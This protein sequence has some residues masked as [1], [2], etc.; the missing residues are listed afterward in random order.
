MRHRSP[1][2]AVHAPARRFDGN[3]GEPWAVEVKAEEKLGAAAMAE[4]SGRA[5]III[6]N[7]RVVDGT[8]ASA[9]RADVAVKDK[10]IVAL[11]ELGHA[12]A[13]SVLDATGL[14]VAPGFIDMHTHSDLSLLI[15][16]R[17]E[18]KLRQGVTTEVIGQCGF[19]PAPA[20][21]PRADAVRAIFGVWGKEVDWS[22]GSYGEYLDALREAGTSV[23]V[24]PVVGHGVLRTGVMGE[25]N[26]PPSAAE[27]DEM[28]AAV[29][30]AMEEGALG[31]SSG[32]AYA[33][34]MFAD[35]EELTALAAEVGVLGGI[36]F[37]HIRGEDER[38]STAVSEAI[39]TGRRAAVRVQISHLKAEGQRNWG[40]TEAALELIDRAGADGVD[41]GF[42]A[43]PYIAWNTGLAQLLPAWA[44]EGGREAV[45]SRLREPAMQV[46]LVGE[47]ADAAQADPGRWERRLLAS[48]GTEANRPLQG[49]TIAE[50]ARLRGRPPEQTVLDL[51]IEEKTDAGMVGFGMSE[52]DVWRV[53]A[54]PLATIGSDSASQA[55]YAVLGKSHPHPRTYGTFARVLG[56][57][58]R[59]QGLFPLEEAV[60][61]MTGR[62]AARLGLSDRG[63][64][65]PGMAADIVVFDP[66]TIVDKATF[67]KPHQYAAGV[68]WVI[69]NGV[70]ELD[71]GEHREKRPGKV[72]VRSR[73]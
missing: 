2:H 41:V 50:I 3:G 48:A 8:G 62:A 52:E 9:R 37:S 27:L 53:L 51:L 4:L 72:L 39:E 57:Y 12:E 68:R 20:P 58:A 1:F 45:L 36:Y 16:P 11:G 30:R 64:I 65:A 33:P 59:E 17:A 61:K 46:R 14:A 22:W 13:E 5:D 38:L 18:S 69:V 43:Y 21:G 70:V 35:T 55:P 24:V 67:E 26:R 63:I 56:H 66:Q 42:D 49:K 73:P 28:R 32:L 25:E 54:H 47:L 31:M 19:S 40:S 10:R 29:R 44:R 15:N 34:G 6:R 7:G 23:N 60:A 71:G